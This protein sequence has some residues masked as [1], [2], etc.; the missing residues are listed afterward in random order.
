M[1]MT[2]DYLR[3]ARTTSDPKRAAK[4]LRKHHELHVRDQILS[5][6][7]CGLH[8]NCAS[9]VPWSGPTTAE[10]VFVG[11]APGATEDKQGKPFVGQAGNMLD[12]VLRS[13]GIERDSVM[14]VNSVCC[15]PPQNRNPTMLEQN[16]CRPNLIAQLD[17][18]EAKVG[19]AMGKAAVETLSGEKVGRMGDWRGSPFWALQRV[20]VPTWHPAYIIRNRDLK[21]ELIADIEMAQ[22][23]VKDSELWPHLSFSDFDLTETFFDDDIRKGLETRQWVKVDSDHLGLT[24]LI[25]R[26]ESIIVPPPYDNEPTYTL[27]ELVLMGAFKDR[28]GLTPDDLRMISHIKT[29][30]GGRVVG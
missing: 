14:V 17:M 7:N 4:F 6:T 5:C 21:F 9:P 24:M 22:K 20:W 26:D 28:L 2:P 19:L 13:L 8:E 25:V 27:K 12:G 29:E 3:A 23:L 1:V 30:L 16:A 15:R 18:C 10:L 11:E